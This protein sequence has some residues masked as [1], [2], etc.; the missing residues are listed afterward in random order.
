MY[1]LSKR[2]PLTFNEAIEKVTSELKEEGFGIITSINLKETFKK[3][4]NTEFRNYIIL[5]ACN[6]H[7]AYKVL[8]LNDKLGVFLPCNVAIQ[9][10]DSGEVE[11]S[12]INPGEVMQAVGDPNLTA[13]AT[14]VTNAMQ[15]VLNRL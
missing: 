1:H 2:I 8:N 3:K 9:Q 15:N 5:G 14:E 6:P 11:V 7:Y 12:I 4:I 13:Y 10:Y